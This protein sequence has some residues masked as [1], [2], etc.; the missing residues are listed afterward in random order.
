MHKKHKKSAVKRKRRRM[1]EKN[2][3]NL[4]KIAESGGTVEKK[5]SLDG[6]HV[7]DF[8]NA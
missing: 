7:G 5:N 1:R 6:K 8:D 3:E 4:K 2:L